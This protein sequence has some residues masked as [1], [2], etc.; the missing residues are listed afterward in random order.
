MEGPLSFL[1]VNPACL[2]LL[3]LGISLVDFMV[4]NWSCPKGDSS[5]HPSTSTV[6]AKKNKKCGNETPLV[7]NYGLRHRAKLLA[8]VK[9]RLDHQF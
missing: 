2:V 1:Q 8:S 7:R 6:S 5:L 4:N 9:R 3:V